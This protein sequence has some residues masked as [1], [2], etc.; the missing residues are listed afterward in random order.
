MK[1]TE[2]GFKKEKSAYFVF[3]EKEIL[4]YGN[5]AK[6]KI[7]Y[8]KSAKTINYQL[9]VNDQEI[10]WRVISKELIDALYE[11]LEEI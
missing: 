6:M 8:H 3:F 7:T 11:E 10:V 2:M 5:I 4:F 1:L 9:R